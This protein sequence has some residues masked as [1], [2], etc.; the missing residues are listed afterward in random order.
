MRDEKDAERR[1]AVKEVESRCEQ[2]YKHFL[3]EHQDTL[4]KALISARQQFQSEK[5]TNICFTTYI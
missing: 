1:V 2:D 4:N 3:C 5:V